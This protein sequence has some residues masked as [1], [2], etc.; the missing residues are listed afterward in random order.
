MEVRPSSERRVHTASIIPHSGPER[1]QQPSYT[2]A[3]EI[4]LSSG[5]LFV[6]VT[7]DGAG[8]VGP[9]R[10]ILC[11]LGVERTGLAG[12]ERPNPRFVISKD[13]LLGDLGFF[14]P[15]FPGTLDGN[16]HIPGVGVNGQKVE[17]IEQPLGQAGM[18]QP[19]EDVTSFPAFHHDAVGAQYGQVL[20]YPGVANPQNGLH[21]VHISLSGAEF[22][23]DP[24]PMRMSEDAEK[25]R[26]LLG[27]KFAF[28]HTSTSI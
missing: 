16:R 24:D 8:R 17:A 22:F 4:G 19:V 3:P 18:G 1:N 6:S 5:T 27:D 14:A 12:I 25:S 28:G 13:P 2:P 21:G 26:H 23:H 7:V 20:G 9:G 10:W 15:D 11:V